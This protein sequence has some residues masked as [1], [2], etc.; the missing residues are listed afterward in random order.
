[1]DLTFENPFSFAWAIL[2][3]ALLGG[4]AYRSRQKLSHPGKRLSLALK[5]LTAACLLLALANP[6]VE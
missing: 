1:M 6:V 5:T 4:I 2:L 3:A